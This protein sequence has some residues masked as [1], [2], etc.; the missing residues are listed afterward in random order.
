MTDADV[1]A[2]IRGNH[3]RANIGWIEKQ[4]RHPKHPANG[5]AITIHWNRAWV[6]RGGTL[7]G[8][9]PYLHVPITGYWA[10]QEETVHR[11][12]APARTQLRLARLWKRER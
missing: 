11:V 2:A 5:Q 8:P 1:V 3:T 4:G 7:F 12:Y 9:G 6:D 10:T